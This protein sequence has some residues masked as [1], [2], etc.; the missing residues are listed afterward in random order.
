M[1]RWAEAVGL[2]TG[3]ETVVAEGAWQ[4]TVEGR[5][6]DAVVA[7]TVAVVAVPRQAISSRATAHAVILAGAVTT[8]I[9]ITAIG[10]AVP[11]RAVVDTIKAV[12]V[13]LFAAVARATRIPT[14][15]VAGGTMAVVGALLLEM[16]PCLRRT[17]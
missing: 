3:A 7:C 10:V 1:V 13:R 15:H 11:L 12:E 17:F 16:A 8:A 14:F 4:I 5:D 9:V 6:A 2:P